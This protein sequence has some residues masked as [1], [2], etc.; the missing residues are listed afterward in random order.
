MFVFLRFLFL[1][2]KNGTSARNRK[3][4]VLQEDLLDYLV[5]VNP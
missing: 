1:S 3:R 2:V 5:K 4:R